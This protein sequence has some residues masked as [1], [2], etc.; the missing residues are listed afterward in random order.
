MGG[1]VSGGTG[2]ICR[3]DLEKKKKKLKNTEKMAF[4]VTS[5]AG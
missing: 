2:G 4:S 5:A 3:R 1:V